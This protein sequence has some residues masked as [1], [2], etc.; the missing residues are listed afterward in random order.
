MCRFT[1]LEPAPPP[2]CGGRLFIQ[3][4]TKSR[5]W[6]QSPGLNV[7]AIV[8]L[9]WFAALSCGAAQ[10]DYQPGCSYFGRSNY[11][12]YIAGD[13]PVIFSVPHGGDVSPAEI[14][15][16]VEGGSSED[17]ADISD[18]YT[19]ELAQAV[20][21]VFHSYFGHTPHIVICH[22]KRTKL[23]C[24]RDI[25][26][27]A[28]GNPRAQE[29]WREYH[30]FIDAAGKAVAA[31]T[32]RGFYIDLHGQ[33]H[34][35]KRVEL[36]Y[37]LTSEQ[38]TNADAVLNQPSYARRSSIRMLASE[39]PVP[40][41]ELLRGSNSFGG[42]L[43]SRGYPC[44][45]DPAMPSPRDCLNSNTSAGGLSPYFSGGYSTRRHTA[46]GQGGPIDGLQMEANL[47]GVRDTAANRARFALALAETLDRFFAT[48]YL[49]NLKTGTVLPASNPS[50]P[51]A[52]GTDVRKQTSR[53]SPLS[54][55]L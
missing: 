48:H 2:S 8:G 53:S 55:P 24:N 38:L 31:S 6:Q 23:D 36:G 44:L 20:K 7:L 13:M 37:I 41:S 22:L 52:L 30:G 40:F 35:I 21:D 1:L 3:R 25:E 9:L 32:G 45:P 47:A 39:V 54:K 27:A 17:F 19:K 26:E 28:M 34:P 14:P 33:S 51:G 50:R 49:I 42:M 5:E 18:A 46:V 29:A 12:E 15:N 16:R 43:V 10:A 4:L 11:V